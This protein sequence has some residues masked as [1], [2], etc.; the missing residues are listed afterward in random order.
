MILSAGE[1]KGCKDNNMFLLCHLLLLQTTRRRN[2]FK[3]Q[4]SFILLTCLQLRLGFVG[5]AHHLHLMWQWE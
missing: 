5:P 1:E 2:G 3:E 4:Q